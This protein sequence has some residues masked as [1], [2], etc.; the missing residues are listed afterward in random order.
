VVCVSTVTACG[1]CE[2]S[3]G[4]WSG[5]S[6]SFERSV[7][8]MKASILDRLPIVFTGHVGSSN[9]GND[10]ATPEGLEGH[11]LGTAG[12]TFGGDVTA[13]VVMESDAMSLGD[14]V[15]RFDRNFWS[16]LQG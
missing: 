9:L 13:S 14:S 3:D 1:L 11:R 10:L 2:Y 5:A 12:L 16:Y 4:L 6:F 15:R 7:E 8:A